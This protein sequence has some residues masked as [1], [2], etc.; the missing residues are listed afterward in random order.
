MSN[1]TEPNILFLLVAGLNLRTTV[2]M[3]EA[4]ATRVF[5]AVVGCAPVAEVSR[6]FP[7]EVDVAQTNYQTEVLIHSAPVAQD[8]SGV[9]VSVTRERAKWETINFSVRRL[10]AGQY[11]QSN[12]RDQEAALVVLGGKATVDWGEG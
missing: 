9:L 10:S 3:L 4:I 7:G 11:W 1:E 2:S 8:K 6:C 12:T 5:P